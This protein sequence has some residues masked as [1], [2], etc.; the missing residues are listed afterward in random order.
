MASLVTNMSADAG[1]TTDGEFATVSRVSV[2]SHAS[3]AGRQIG[4]LSHVYSHVV[5]DVMG[6]NARFFLTRQGAGAAIA[7]AA[8][9]ITDVTVGDAAFDAMWNVHADEAVARGARHGHSSAADR[10]QVQ[11]QPGEPRLGC[12]RDDPTHQPRPRLALARRLQ[13]G[14]RVVHSRPTHR[15]AHADIGAYGS[16]GAS[17][18][19]TGGIPRVCGRGARGGGYTGERCRPPAAPGCPACVGRVTERA[20]TR[21]GPRGWLGATW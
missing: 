7:R 11:G 21:R 14:A 15:Y 3:T 19:G 2:A 12:R 20:R 8:G 5:V 18:T 17:S 10:S 9:A 1:F 16:A 13:R 6:V 4:E